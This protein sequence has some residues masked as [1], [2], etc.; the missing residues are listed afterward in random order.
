MALTAIAI[1]GMGVC[2][3][4]PQWVE[5]CCE[6][7]LFIDPKTYRHPASIDSQTFEFIY[8]EFPALSAETELPYL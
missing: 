7:K 3:V 4:T 1:A 6:A 2:C 5:D 8:R